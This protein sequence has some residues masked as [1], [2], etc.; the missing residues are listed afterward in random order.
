MRLDALGQQ[1]EIGDAVVFSTSRN[2][3]LKKGI[4]TEFTP[5]GVNVKYLRYNLDCSRNLATHQFVKIFSTC[6]QT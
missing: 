1:V 4:I 3:S 2:V 5:C 6:K